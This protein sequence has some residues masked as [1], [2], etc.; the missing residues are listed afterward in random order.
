MTRSEILAGLKS[1]RTLVID[2][3]DEPN[4]PWLLELADRGQLKATY[5][6]YDEQSSAI[7]FTWEE[8]P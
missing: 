2:R 8:T 3:K 6:E 5:V 4:L 7:K 1:G